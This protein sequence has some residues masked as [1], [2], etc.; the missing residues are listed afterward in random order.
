MK[1][2]LFILLT[3]F[4]A[5]CVATNKP[6]EGGGYGYEEHKLGDGLFYVKYVFLSGDGFTE[7]MRHDWDKRTVVVCNNGVDKKHVYL[8]S[9]QTLSSG[10]GLSFM[11]G[12]PIAYTDSDTTAVIEGVVQCVDSS[13]SQQEVRDVLVN[14]MF[15]IDG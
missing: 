13:M 12:I 9:M 4:L 5:S 2:S 3:V 7:S 14:E 8:E 1:H 10:T 6:R 15:L 11:G